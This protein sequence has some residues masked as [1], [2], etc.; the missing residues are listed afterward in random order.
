MKS[1]P[2]YIELLKCIPYIKCDIFLYYLHFIAERSRTRRQGKTKRDLNGISIG[3]IFPGGE[4][5]FTM[6]TIG[7]SRLWK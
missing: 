6:R 4:A 2:E 1:V 7:F 5:K 3:F